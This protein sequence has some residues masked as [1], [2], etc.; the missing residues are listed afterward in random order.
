MDEIQ[1]SNPNPNPNIKCARGDLLPIATTE[2]HTR[3]ACSYFR[4]VNKTH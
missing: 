1:R 4:A 3:G 2:T